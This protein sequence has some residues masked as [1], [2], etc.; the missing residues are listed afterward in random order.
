MSVTR[1]IPDVFRRESGS[2]NP[3]LVDQVLAPALEMLGSFV[4]GVYHDGPLHDARWIRIG[5]LRVL[6]QCVSGRDFLQ[7]LREVGGEELARASF[8][9]SL[10]SKP[11]QDRLAHLNTELVLRRGALLED[12]LGNF[13]ELK[14]RPIYAVDGHHLAHATHARRDAEGEQVSSNSLYVLSL[15][16][17]LLLNLAAVQ[18]NGER[19]HELPIFRQRV[20]PWLVK[21][22][23]HRGAKPIFVADPAFVDKR[24]WTQMQLGW[25]DGALVITRTK[26]NMKPIVSGSRN[27]DPNAPANQ[28]VLADESVV[29][30]GGYPMRRVQYVDPETGLE[31]EFLTTVLDLAPGL[32][33]LLYLLRWRIEKVFDTG[34]NKL[35]ETKAW[36]AGSVAQEIQAHFFALTHNLLL[37]LRRHLEQTQDLREV[38]VEQKRTVA[39]VARREQLTRAGRTVSSFRKLL[40]AVVQL[41]AQFIRTL[42]NGILVR[43]HWLQALA[44]L[45]RS[46]ESY[47]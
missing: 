38:K 46:M 22:G 11:R 14:D 24:F 34:K 16:T 41:T 2:V 27:W 43:I 12:L 3:L 32:I 42:R 36:A 19:H 31:Y 5:V 29:F 25:K 23:T 7:Q 9:G 6:S 4:R 39:S 20:I 28:G 45:R 1:S 8:F 15:H 17:G 21:H 37:L 26:E 47:L 40:P 13:P 44:L 10:H 33:A 35:E 30:P 18:G